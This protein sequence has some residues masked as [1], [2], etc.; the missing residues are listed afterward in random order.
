MVFRTNFPGET[1][2]NAL[3][4]RSVE[5][6]QTIPGIC[7]LHDLA[8]QKI[9]GLRVDLRPPIG[10]A[11]EHIQGIAASRRDF[12]VLAQQP[13]HS[14]SQSEVDENLNILGG[15]KALNR[16]PR[17][18]HPERIQEHHS[19]PARLAEMTFEQVL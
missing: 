19:F 12:R 3:L 6:E 7:P 11:K 14:H 4:R 5:L 1:R 13:L 2:P 15:A 10:C 17:D 9:M 18:V 16:R 8:A